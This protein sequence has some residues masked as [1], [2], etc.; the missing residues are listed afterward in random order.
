MESTLQHC[1]LCKSSSL[2]VVVDLGHQVITSRFPDVGDKS[3]PCTRVRLVLCAN[4]KLVQLKDTTHCSELYEHL[5]GYRSGLNE[6]MCRHLQ[7]YNRELQGL[8]HGGLKRGDMVLDIGS[9]DATFLKFYDKGENMGLKRVGCDPTGKQFASCYEGNEDLELVDTYFTKEALVQVY[10]PDVKFR[11]VSSISMF[12]DLPDPVQFARDVYDLLEENGVWTLEQSYVATMLERNSIDTICHEHLEYYGVRQIK[13]IMDRAGFKIIKLGLN[14]CNGGSFRIYVAKRGCGVY[15]ED[16][17]AVRIFLEQEELHGIHTIEA[18]KAFNDRCAVQAQRLKTFLQWC[19]DDKKKVYIY[20]ASTKGNCLLQYAGVGPD[21]VPYAVERNPLKY[22][23][24]TS[25]EIPII[26]EATMRRDNPD[27][28]LVLPWH[29]REGIVAREAD[30]LEGGGTLIFPFPN[31]TLVSKKKRALITGVDGQISKYLVPKLEGMYHIIGQCRTLEHHSRNILRLRYDF[32]D[33]SCDS[34]GWLQNVYDIFRPEVIIH[35]ASITNTESCE[36]NPFGTMKLNGYLIGALCEI[37]HKSGVPCKLFHASS[38]EI[39]KK[40]GSYIVKDDDNHVAPQ[41]LYGV[42]KSFGHQIVDYYRSKY[43]LPFFNGVLFTT[44]SRYRKNNFLLRKV[45]QHALG[46][47]RGAKSVLQLGSLESYRNISHADDVAQAI[48]CMLGQE[49]GGNYVICNED[50]WKV[51]DLV[52][53][54]YKLFGIELKKEGYYFVID[55]NEKEK[56][57]EIGH[58]LREN[59]TRIHGMAEK[60][61]KLGWVPRYSVDDILRDVCELD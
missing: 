15:K 6:M 17:D 30:Y 23:K 42:C 54:I 2:N 14:E 53:K 22:G 51:E 13:E 38:S 25:T 57:L 35:N 61:K 47:S 26:D 46:W 11:V 7:E 31:F 41:T 5:Y 48:V 4:C 21:L 19:R 40:H 43:N 18:Y 52:L 1:R 20:G 24:M 60:L 37:I 32:E 45:F 34:V 33:K 9:N 28:L 27:Y 36:N 56:V 59:A 10:G 8:V 44:E 55:D 12:Y 16:V 29:F 58:N 49:V 3:T 50:L 39:Y